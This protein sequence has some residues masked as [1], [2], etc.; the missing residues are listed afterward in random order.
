RAL[1][2]ALV[3]LLA[4]L[5]ACDNGGAPLET[6]REGAAYSV[7]DADEFTA[8]LGEIA[9]DQSLAGTNDWCTI[10]VTAD[11]SLESQVL[12]YGFAG[13]NIV[14]KGDN[15]ERTIMF[16]KTGDAALFEIANGSLTLDRNITLQGVDKTANHKKALVVVRY[17]GQLVINDG[18]KITGN[19]NLTTGDPDGVGFTGGGGVQLV[20]GGTLVMNGGE[21]SGNSATQGS[22]VGMWRGTFIMKGGVIKDNGTYHFDSKIASRGGGVHMNYP[23]DFFTMSGGNIIGNKATRGGGVSLCCGTFTMKGDSTLISEN[24]AGSTGGGV[25]ICCECLFKMEGGVI[26]K[27][28]AGVFAATDTLDSARNLQR[29]GGGVGRWGSGTWTGRI[30]WDSPVEFIKTGGIIYGSDA[31]ENANM[32]ENGGA[33]DPQTPDETDPGKFV[34]GDAIYMFRPGDDGSVEYIIDGDVT[35]NYAYKDSA[36]PYDRP[37]PTA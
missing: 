7:K 14:L 28:R 3:L 10:T 26:S 17:N 30:L 8:A 22:G 9:A 4:S 23:E 2:M 11:F 35:G 25:G 32:V 34:K 29:Y 13:K 5:V 6:G 36:E 16:S 1:F 24:V 37:A 12:S 20:N 19:V 33:R 31:G 15:G 21:I 18:A 27:N